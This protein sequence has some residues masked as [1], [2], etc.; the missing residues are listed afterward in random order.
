MVRPL[1][2]AADSP[3]LRRLLVVP[4]WSRI[5]IK[6]KTVAALSLLASASAFAPAQTGSRVRHSSRANNFRGNFLLDRSA[7]KSA[8]PAPGSRLASLMSGKKQMESVQ[9]MMDFGAKNHIRCPALQTKHTL[10]FSRLSIYFREGQGLRHSSTS[11]LIC[12]GDQTSQHA[13]SI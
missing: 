10:R 8:R 5:Q 7:R 1:A 6:M 3:L 4:C 11:F 9:N 12:D 13:T 2:A